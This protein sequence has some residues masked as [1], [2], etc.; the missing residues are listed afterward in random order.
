MDRP[1]LS[2][3]ICEANVGLSTG[4]ILGNSDKESRQTERDDLNFPG[5]SKQELKKQTQT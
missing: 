1:N 4:V 5:P 2:A 3:F